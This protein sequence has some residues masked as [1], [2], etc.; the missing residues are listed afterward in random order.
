MD[1]GL[2]GKNAVVTGASRGIGRAIADHLAAEGARVAYVSRGG[3]ELD[4]AVAE[5]GSRA[6]AVVGD[7]TTSDG[8]ASIAAAALAAFGSVDILVNNVGGSGARTF[9]AADEADLQLALDRNL[10]PAFRMSKALLP[11]MNVGGAIL[12]IT[13]IWGR[14]GGGGPTYNAAKAAEISLGKAM[15]RDLARRGIRVNTLAP[16]S[17]FFE[18]GGWQR[19]QKADPDGI[20]AFVAAELPF[21]RFGKPEEVAAVAA[22]LCSPRASWVA[23][24]CI[25]VDGCQSRMF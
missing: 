4:A 24:A 8:V 3:A 19:R 20:A 15:A 10:W 12:H 11:S 9:D 5:A 1:L 13:S 6:L 17:I 16:G 14:E 2:Q 22:F 7:V 25:V 23:G 18:G 21:G